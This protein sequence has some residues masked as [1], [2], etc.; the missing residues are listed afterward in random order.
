MMKYLSGVILLLCVF[1]AHSAVIHAEKLGIAVSEQKIAFDMDTMEE[2]SVVVKVT[3][4]SDN[5]QKIG[6]YPI[7]YQ[8]GDENMINFIDEPDMEYGVR[9]WVT[10][11]ESEIVLPAHMS[12]DVKLTVR[13]PEHATVGSHRGAILF[14]AAT[15]DNDATVA[16]QGQIGVH[17]LINIKGNTHATGELESFDVPFFTVGDVR[18]KAVFKNNG[19]I[20]YI[21][22]GGITTFNII[23]KKSVAYDFN[24]GD[25]FVFPG[26]TYTFDIAKRIPSLFGAYQV[27]AQFVDGEGAVRTKN[28]YVVGALFPVSIVLLVVLVGGVVAVVIKIRHKREQKK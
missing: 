23:T 11:E 6:V 19:N 17:V 16:V 7:D 12:K 8:L 27:R 21:P 1:F 25:H 13:V 18:Y 10:I 14:R 3:N 15:A 4:V 9:E 20:H 26:K 2:Q 5:E 28:D 24:E 22:H